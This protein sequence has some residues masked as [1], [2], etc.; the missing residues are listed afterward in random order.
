M[1]GCESYIFNWKAPD[2]EIEF[3][4]WEME[5][6]IELMIYTDDVHELDRGT[7]RNA[8]VLMSLDGEGRKQGIYNDSVSGKCWSRLRRIVM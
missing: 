8:F 6:R 2:M 5:L 4:R 7:V 1:A 3:R